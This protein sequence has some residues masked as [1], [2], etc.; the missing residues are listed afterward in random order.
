MRIKLNRKTSFI[1][2]LSLLTMFCSILV[3]CE[4]PYIYDDKEPDFLSGS[5]EDIYTTLKRDGHFT[6]FLRLIDDLNYTDVLSKTGSKTLFPVKDDAFERFFASNPY[7]VKKYEDFTPA[8]KRNIMNVSMLDMAYL[9]YMLAN[10]ASSNNG[11]IGEGLALRHTTANTYLDSVSFVSDPL[12]LNSPFWT[13]YKT[14]GGLYLVDNEEA[15]SFIHFTQE[16]MLT[17]K[18]SNE[19]F[20]VINNGTVYSPKDIYVNGIKVIEQDIICK[21]GY[22][23]V[24]EELLLP[25]QNISQIIR[26]NGQTNL[27]CKLMEKFSLPV[28]SSNIAHE[29]H[30]YYDGRDADHSLIPVSDSIF[31]KRYLT[32]N[33]ISNNGYGLKDPSGNALTES[34]G[35]LHFDPSSNGYGSQQ[36]VGVM[37]VPT[38]EAMN[39]YI[40][41]AKGLYLKDAYGSWENIPTP[42][43]SLF[44]K[45]HQKKSFLSA[46][47]HMWPTMNDESS[48]AMNVSRE[49]IIKAYTG[50]NGIVYVSN[51]VYP[52]VDYQSVYGAVL[53]SPVTRIMNWCIQDDSKGMMY[54]RY[55]RSMENMYNLI[56]P[57]DVAFDNYRDPVSWAKGEMYRQIWSF[58]YDI[59]YNRVYAKLYLVDPSGNKGEFLGDMTD[60]NIIKNRL[61]DIIDMHIVV[62]EKIGNQMSGYID[63]GATQ[64]AL[65]KG[66]AT[67]KVNGA[68]NN[69]TLTGGGDIEQSVVPAHIE[70][71]PNT[72][73]KYVYDSDNGRT[74]FIDKIIEDPTKSLYTLLGE[75]PEYTAFFDLLRGNDEVFEYFLRLKDP[76]VKSIFDL[77]IIGN[78]SGLG[79]VVNSFNNFRYTVFVP[80]EA[81]LNA[82]FDEDPN[83]YRWEDI[84][85]DT[86][87]TTKKAKTIYL[88]NFLKYHFMDNSIFIDGKNVSNLKYETAALNAE[89]RFRKV[90]ISS[91]GTS[92][93][94]S[95]ET[96]TIKANVIKQ[97]GVYNLMARD[98]IVDN[99]DYKAALNIISSSRSVVHLIDK[100]LRFDN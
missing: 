91:N 95:N 75:H 21:N 37:F 99:K 55:L 5:I 90:S 53:T 58:Y 62:G 12:L 68:G 60:Q 72:N 87:F 13:Y 92:M 73:N 84:A 78:T 52:P 34:Y 40:N 39:T 79:Y 74:Y 70:T 25:P 66:G 69:M 6:N 63:D 35:V 97:D 28:Y 77:K 44:I 43:L 57:L 27:F 80:T 10:S 36:D 22:V 86:I 81:A 9:S 4:D 96:G 83:L 41:S 85:L 61:K 98:Y 71:N 20:S 38:D 8:Q 100:A 50:N 14:K 65:T 32:S 54:Y 1:L 42:V 31:V 88:L 89:D 49:Q 51:V 33:F 94:V 17:Q 3:S 26:K 2:S 93:S 82:A 48:F 47:P 59:N 30:A 45:N 11:S 15:I 16:N 18:I 46:L 56:I 19:D 67:I 23:H 76:D 64:Y 7:G 24:L 29:V